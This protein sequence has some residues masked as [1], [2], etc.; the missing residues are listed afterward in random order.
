MNEVKAISRVKSFLGG[1]PFELQ[2]EINNWIKAQELNGKTIR[3]ISTSLTMDLTEIDDDG[4][5]FVALV[6]FSITAKPPPQHSNLENGEKQ[7]KTGVIKKKS[8]VLSYQVE[9]KRQNINFQP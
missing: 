4:A 2:K 3:I 5:V 8:G 1:D 6:G 9:E 7:N